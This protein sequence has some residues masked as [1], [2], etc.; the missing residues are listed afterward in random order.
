[1]VSATVILSAFLSTI[2][3]TRALRVHNNREIRCDQRRCYACK[4]E[5]TSTTMPPLIGVP[6]KHCGDVCD[7]CSQRRRLGRLTLRSY[8]PPTLNRSAS[9]VEKL[10]N[11]AVEE[12]DQKGC[13]ACKEA[14]PLKRRC[15]YVCVPC[16]LSR[17]SCI[18]MDKQ[19]CARVARS[20]GLAIGTDNDA[21]DFSDPYTGK[22]SY[23]PGCYA[24]VSGP[25]KGHAYFGSEVD[26][27]EMEKD[28]ISPKSRVRG[29]CHSATEPSPSM[30]LSST[31][32]LPEVGTNR[33]GYISTVINHHFSFSTPSN[34]T[35]NGIAS[36]RCS[37]CGTRYFLR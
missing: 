7:P 9:R 26:P 33:V 15:D 24:Y 19:T 27:G 29:P 10:H 8:R 13:D 17:K 21:A 2:C 22:G 37:E 11:R 34:D 3:D 36:D 1:M 35:S 20:L 31:T 30:L 6:P 12:C 23:S 18:P 32:P 25:Y 14:Y 28:L 5:D 16:S 4:G